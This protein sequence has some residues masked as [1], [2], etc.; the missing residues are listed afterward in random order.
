MTRWIEQSKTEK[1][2]EALCDLLVKEQLINSCPE[3][4]AIHLRERDPQNLA[5]AAKVAEQFL[6]AH[7]KSL[8]SKLPKGKP[9]PLNGSPTGGDR[10]GKPAGKLQCYGCGGYGHRAADCKK[11]P[12]KPP[13]KPEKRCFLCDR[14]S[15]FARECKLGKDTK[16][17]GKAGTALHDPHLGDYSNLESCIHGDQLLLRNGKTLP[18]IKSGSVSIANNAE[19]KLPVVKGTVNEKMINTLRDTGCSGVVVRQ[20]LVSGEQFTGKF[21]YMLLIDNTLREV[22][23]ARIRVDT[24]YLKGEVTAQCLLVPIY[25]LIIGNVPG[26]RAPDDSDP[27]WQ[28]A[29][30]MTTRSQV[31]KGTTT[32]PLIVPEDL[33]GSA[34]HR[35][36]LIQLQEEN[37]SLRK[38][39]EQ[40]SAKEPRDGEVVFEEKHGILYQVFRKRDEN[41]EQITRQV[42]VPLPLRQEVMNSEENDG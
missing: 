37:P 39:R 6:I 19:S 17:P 26:A 32:K 12:A 14:T 30:A 8:F 5:M 27:S 20:S 13:A 31:K 18:F 25:D 42:M 3:D 34:I 24:P 33:R 10:G 15:H 9:G 36:D 11:T 38:Y 21:G 16:N 2:F 7:S 23:L 4:L 22:P 28:E 41:A 29:S 40:T 1:S 35:E